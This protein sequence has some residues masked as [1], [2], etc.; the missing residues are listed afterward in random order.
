MPAAKPRTTN[1]RTSANARTTKPRPVKPKQFVDASGDFLAFMEDV[2]RRD[3]KPFTIGDKTFHLRGPALLSDEEVEGL[4]TDPSVIGKA[5]A[6]IDDYDGFAAA[7]GTAMMLMTYW[8]S[9][10]D[11]EALGEGPAS[12]SS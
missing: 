5:R 9:V 3:T 12:S 6:V 8:D 10:F 7:G 11:A 1:S 2:K 4:N